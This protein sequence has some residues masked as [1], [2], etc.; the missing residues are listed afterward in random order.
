MNA[1]TLYQLS[2]QYRS[3][4]R[5]ADSDELPPEVIR[6]TL[7]A[8]SGELDDKAVSVAHF[9]RN[10]EEAAESIQRAAAAMTVRADRLRDRATSLREYLLFHMQATNKTRI[11]SVYFT[12]AVRT[13]PPAVVVD[14]ESAV[15]AQFKVQP[16]APAPRL[17]RTMIAAHLKAGDTVPGCHIVTRQRLEIKI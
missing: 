8:L 14:D 7:D 16:P 13:N 10:L 6:D 2:E 15:P 4:E 12:L 5:L 3:L 1:L 9:V 17:D 11:D